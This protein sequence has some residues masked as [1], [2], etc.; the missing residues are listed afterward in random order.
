MPDNTLLF[1]ETGVHLTEAVYV[2]RRIWEDYIPDEAKG[3]AADQNRS[4]R[5]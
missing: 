1:S 3:A 5:S 2:G 4:W